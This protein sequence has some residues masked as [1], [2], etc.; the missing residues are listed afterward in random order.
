MR[1]ASNPEIINLIDKADRGGA[2]STIILA[3]VKALDHIKAKVMPNIKARKF[4]KSLENKKV[5]G[6]ATFLFSF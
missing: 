4:I 2:L 5:A 6:L 3:E 1:T